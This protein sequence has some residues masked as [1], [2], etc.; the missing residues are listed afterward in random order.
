MR[1]GVS[2]PHGTGKSTLVDELCGRLAGHIRVDEPYF[3]LEEEGR[4]FEFP[5]SADDYRAQLRRSLR[6][7]TT[8]S[9]GVVFDRTPLDFLAYLSACGV[10]PE[11]E[12]E[13]AIVRSAL[14]TL[15]V[16][17]VVPITVETV[18]KL[19]AV[20]MPEL[21]RAV[22]DA[23]LELVYADP[24]QVCDSLVVVELDGPLRG[25]VDTVLSALQ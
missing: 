18:Q 15:D 5:P 10:D 17:V 3:V 24:M 11:A 16:L 20:G 23:L 7:L 19:P 13:A 1:I 4:E 21:Q 6:L 25:R 2:G 8:P 9:S 22:N 14:C 12:V